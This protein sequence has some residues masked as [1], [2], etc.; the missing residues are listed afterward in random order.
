[1]GHF[2]ALLEYV[3]DNEQSPEADNEEQ[4]SI[5]KISL[6]YRLYIKANGTLPFPLGELEEKSNQDLQIVLFSMYEMTNEQLKIFKNIHRSLLET[7]T[8]EPYTAR[9]TLTRQAIPSI[10]RLKKNLGNAPETIAPEYTLATLSDAI[11]A[12]TTYKDILRIK[13]ENMSQ[14]E[15]AHQVAIKKWRNLSELFQMLTFSDAAS[16]INNR[17][18]LEEVNSHVARLERDL[19]TAIKAFLA[20]TSQ[21]FD[22]I[23]HDYDLEAPIKMLK[24]T[25][26]LH[27]AAERKDAATMIKMA[28]AIA[29]NVQKM[30]AYKSNL[31]ERIQLLQQYV[32][33]ESE[34]ETE[35]SADQVSIVMERLITTIATGPEATT[36]TEKSTVIRHLKTL[37][38]ILTEK[39]NSSSAAA[40]NQTWQRALSALKNISYSFHG[41]T[42]EKIH[43][44]AKSLKLTQE[45]VKK[46]W[47]NIDQQYN[48]KVAQRCRFRIQKSSPQRRSALDSLKEKLNG[49][50]SAEAA[51]TL[52][53][54]T[55]QN[56]FEDHKK[57]SLFPG[58]KSYLKELLDNGIKT[59]R[60]QLADQL[61][62]VTMESS[63]H[64]Q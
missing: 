36:L 32:S 10:S 56:V 18:S 47:Q 11:K 8:I 43:E 53:E 44:T 33:A 37:L 19:S 63:L 52:F 12:I 21:H 7:L 3:S 14:Q 61:S 4:T 49:V 2:T 27:A 42:P 15:A 64:P 22:E 25:V 51:L 62:E 31:A 39:I 57:N 48:Q 50:V 34:N 35:I 24:D 1:M 26:T 38:D 6:L 59:L 29:A 45:T 13:Q 30:Q 20:E 54:D 16:T 9:G 58:T 17:Q 28:K 46:I 41:K 40:N 55:R 5:N 23:S 60:V